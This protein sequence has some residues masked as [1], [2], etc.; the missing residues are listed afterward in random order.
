MRNRVKRY[1][2][3][4]PSIEDLIKN[5]EGEAKRI[6]DNKKSDLYVNW[7][8][9]TPV[10]PEDR[11]EV[12]NE[13]LDVIDYE[14]VLKFFELIKKHGAFIVEDIK[15]LIETLPIVMVMTKEKGLRFAVGISE[16][17]GR[18]PEEIHNFENKNITKAIGIGEALL[19]EILSLKDD[20]I[21]PLIIK[22]LLQSL[23]MILTK[24][25]RLNFKGFDID[26]DAI[27]TYTDKQLKEMKETFNGR[28]D[29]PK[30]SPYRR[31][32][33]TAYLDNEV[34]NRFYSDKNDLK[35]TA[36]LGKEWDGHFND[37][38]DEFNEKEYKRAF[39]DSD[40]KEIENAPFARRDPLLLCHYPI[41]FNRAEER[42]DLI[43]IAQRY[44]IPSDL[45]DKAMRLEAEA[46]E[47]IK[48]EI[49]KIMKEKKE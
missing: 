29:L 8:G 48:P 42:I 9:K 33:V 31:Y 32:F 44:G 2:R 5:I 40:Y 6:L 20:A 13:G 45:I 18:I 22:H 10:M 41:C 11:L 30:D 39:T 14:K 23:R 7:A 47:I 46:L 49:D 15:P 27:G 24:K 34:Y 25:D 28:K 21:K 1:M 26:Y 37:L 3:N 38:C 12:D 43:E 4:I 16:M 36:E 19:D 17:I 35:Y